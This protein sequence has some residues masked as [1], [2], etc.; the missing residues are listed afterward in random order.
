MDT[1]TYIV[2]G[3][4]SIV[5]DQAE[6]YMLL[7]LFTITSDS[8]EPRALREDASQDK[9]QKKIDICRECTQTNLRV[10]SDGSTVE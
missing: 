1:Q 10:S 8:T 9:I 7:L 5:L 3:E 2:L 6:K 4:I